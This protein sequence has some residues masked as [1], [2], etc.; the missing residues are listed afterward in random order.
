MFKKSSP[1]KHKEEGHLMLTEKGHKEAHGGEIP[2]DNTEGFDIPKFNYQTFE[3]ENDI[4][5]TVFTGEKG[6]FNL[7]EANQIWTDEDGNIVDDKDVPEEYIKKNKKKLEATIQDKGVKIRPGGE[8]LWKFEYTGGGVAGNTAIQ[9]AHAF[10]ATEE[11]MESSAEF[12]DKSI[13]DVLK[14]TREYGALRKQHANPLFWNQF[15]NPMMKP[16]AGNS[17]AL[18]AWKRDQVLREQEK[19]KLEDLQSRKSISR[20]KSSLLARS[21]S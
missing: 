21:T 3:D 5:P 17:K 12:A 9:N 2:E 16:T 15:A 1:L 19:Q 10:K 11:Q 14:A 6:V 18:A 13:T 8:D 20:S 4:T 7:D